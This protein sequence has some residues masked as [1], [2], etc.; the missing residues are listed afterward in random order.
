MMKGLLRSG[1]GLLAIGTALPVLA[2]AGDD[3][4]VARQSG[5]D[6]GEAGGDE[7]I[8]TA[9]RRAEQLIDVPIA[10]SVISGEQLDRAGI[11]DVRDLQYRVPAL[12][13][14]TNTSSRNTVSYA[15]R[16]Q[17]VHE[18]NLLTDPAINTYFAEV[19]QPRTYGFGYSM[20]DI[21]S[22]QVLRG[23]QGTLFGRN[24]TGGAVLVEPNRPELGRTG[25]EVRFTTGSF[26]LISGYGMLN[27]PLGDAIAV[28]FAGEYRTRDGFTRDLRNDVDLDD[29]DYLTL[30]G[31][32]LVQPSD[33]FS[34]LTIVDHLDSKSNGSSAILTVIRQTG[35]PASTASRYGQALADL[36]AQQEALGP[37]QVIG[38]LV[39]GT[40]AATNPFPGLGT[41][42]ALE[43]TGLTNR[44]EIQIGALRLKN[45]LGYRSVSYDRINDF[46][47]IPLTLLT[48]RLT[49][50]ISQFSEE[51]Q[52]QGSLFDDRLDFTLG[53]YFF[54]EE[55]DEI[56][57]SVQFPD[58]TPPLT[59]PAADKAA[60]TI[61]FGR[62]DTYS[63]YGA[64]T[65]RL[66]DQFKLSVG[67]RWTR[68]ERFARVSN[69]TA[70][71][72]CRLTTDAGTPLDGPCVLTNEVGSSAIT[73]DAALN[74]EPDNRTT[75]YAAIRRGY[76]AG[77]FNLRARSPAQLAPFEPE[78]VREYE[79]GSKRRWWL[80]NAQ[81][82]TDLALFLQDYSNI[83]TSTT[84]IV[85]GRIV[86]VISNT[87]EQ[88]NYGLEFETT[89]SVGRLNLSGYYSFVD[90][91][92][93]RG[94]AGDFRLRGIPRHTV[95]LSGQYSIP[96]LDGRSSID[97]SGNV[98]YRSSF[99]LDDFDVVSRQAGY[100]LANARIDFIDVVTP[101]LSLG[102]YVNNITDKL[103]RLG[104]TSLLDNVGLTSTIFSEPRTW[105]A[106]ARYRF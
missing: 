93:V 52:L 61:G 42:D 45:V 95:G 68:D 59:A 2:Q 9:R 91:T 82:T 88:V 17:R 29:L 18:Y 104:E 13:I 32:L 70:A 30:R 102:V 51:L 100:V 6:S 27:L 44:T 56:A 92:N 89:L 62:S 71:G 69:V 1:V 41:F 16:G 35:T 78:Y 37:R 49:T 67:L 65:Y 86:G 23:V 83:Q 75:F 64:G 54:R 97:L 81:L 50:D 5:A 43:N 28:R 96:I 21:G 101:G 66:S 11:T 94:S 85:D 31:S 19:V 84:A 105:G 90:I 15:I 79:L 58:I 72:A 98:S 4:A 24:A 33:A 53:G 48:S 10:V 103:Y 26:D 74:Y 36:L 63:V 60:S 7:I 46:Y 80:G 106:V 12:Q 57:T 55:G 77:G 22:V 3:P 76:R 39:D 34:N 25:G 8:V 38:S 20:I 14:T 99:P 73:W 87:A 47:Y 40:D